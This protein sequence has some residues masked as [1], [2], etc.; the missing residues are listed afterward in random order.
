MKDIAT[1]C[2]IDDIPSVVEGIATQIDWAGC[3]IRVAG[4]ALDGE[5]GLQLIRRER[6]DIV[7]TDIRMPNMDGIEMMTKLKEAEIPSKMIFFSGYTDF[8]Y[9]QQAVRLGAF[10]Y[11]TKPHS[12]QQITDIVLKA[13]E[14]VLAERRE[15]A[16]LREIEGKV[17]DS[18]PILRQE[19]FNLLLRHP[20]S[21]SSV[22]RRWAFLQIDMPQT[23][24]A[25]MVIEIDQF[26]K[27]CGHL[28]IEEIELIRFSLQ[29]IVE[30]TIGARTSGV[31]FRETMSRFVAVYH[32]PDAFD[33]SSWPSSAASIS[34]ASRNLP[35]P[36]GTAAKR[37]MCRKSPA[38]IRMR[39][40]PSPISFTPT[41][42][43]C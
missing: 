23:D 30:E 27:R 1:L 41:A 29:N 31:V 24:L 38:P 18:L 5:E 4:T 16:R 17:K 36:S 28:P 26:D 2:I 25:V 43:W 20:T 12:L 40:S 8:E 6:P 13:R 3:G 7:L 15:Q 14:T 9:A 39:S 33:T 22:Q 32:A 42:M 19:F 11:L 34:R 35:Y 21:A 10:D 37:P